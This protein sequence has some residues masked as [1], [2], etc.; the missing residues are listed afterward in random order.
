MATN[1]AENQWQVFQRPSIKLPPQPYVRVEAN[2]DCKRVL[3]IPANEALCPIVIIELRPP[4]L[5]LRCA[6]V[7]TAFSAS[8]QGL[9][10]LHRFAHKR[11]RKSAKS[12]YSVIIC[13]SARCAWN[14][15]ERGGHWLWWRRWWPAV[16]LL[17]RNPISRAIDLITEA[18][19]ERADATFFIFT[20]YHS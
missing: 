9:P 13:G 15:D 12:H 6:R 3:L 16:Q 18:F 17:N 14:I 4:K 2:N 7:R 10:P 19:C 1:G 8:A 5:P 20:I 11:R